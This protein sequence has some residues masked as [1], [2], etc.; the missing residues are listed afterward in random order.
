MGFSQT[1]PRTVAHFSLG[2]SEF[3]EGRGENNQHRGGGMW[4]ATALGW[5]VMPH[6]GAEQ[7]IALTKTCWGIQ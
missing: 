5:S 4:G 3:G 1:A 7:F 6:K 2:K